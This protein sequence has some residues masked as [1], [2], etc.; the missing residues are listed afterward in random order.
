VLSSNLGLLLRLTMRSNAGRRTRLRA[1]RQQEYE[2][3]SWRKRCHSRCHAA[4]ASKRP[5]ERLG[6]CVRESQSWAGRGDWECHAHCRRYR[7][8]LEGY[9]R[10]AAGHCR[11]GEP[12]PSHST[13]RAPFTAP[14]PSHHGQGA[15]CSSR[16]AIKT[17]K[18]RGVYRHCN[19]ATCQQM[20]HIRI[21]MLHNVLLEDN[22]SSAGIP[23][24]LVPGYWHLLASHDA[25]SGAPWALLTSALHYPY[26]VRRRGWL[27]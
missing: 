1:P 13:T 8:W 4:L 7:G 3:Q 23:A 17:T 6:N 19:C 16:A 25:Q 27:H 5:P 15:R 26:G 9:G 21:I 14:T 10:S 2:A 24:A 22:T 18:P 20:R 12:E 11:T